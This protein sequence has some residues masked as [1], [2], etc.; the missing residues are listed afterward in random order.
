MTTRGMHYDFKQ[1]L[2]KIDSNQY[3]NLK[4]PEIDW[5]LN[6]ALNIFILNQYA[7]KIER[8]SGFETSQRNIDSIRP[9]VKK[10]FFKTSQIGK[11]EFLLTLP[12][13]YTFYLS[14]NAEMKRGSCEPI[15]TRAT[16]VQH[17]D[18]FERTEFYSSSYEWEQVNFRFVDKGVVLYS[19]GSFNIDRVELTYLRKHSYIHNAQDFL[20]TGSYKLDDGTILT[21][22]VN[23]ELPD[24]THSE[25][26]DI[27]VLV[28]T[29]DLQKPDFEIKKFKTLI[30]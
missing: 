30:N 19:D 21:G 29:G 20:P 15:M 3:R 14:L 5:K 6:E 16:F 27:A 25:I 1:K 13:D 12:R 28:S 9:L 7:P 10:E 8:N 2:N 22:M 11:K 23:C 4:I 26:V 18:Y 24:F 17:D